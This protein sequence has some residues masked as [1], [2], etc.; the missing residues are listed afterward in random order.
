MF[1][2]QVALGNMEEEVCVSADYLEA[3][4][5]FPVD[6]A[7]G[8]GHPQVFLAPPASPAWHERCNASTYTSDFCMSY[9]SRHGCCEHA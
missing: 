6:V 1:R 8:Y 5:Q 2:V 9:P 7:R 3:S 4:E